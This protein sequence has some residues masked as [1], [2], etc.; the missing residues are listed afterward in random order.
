MDNPC[1][2]INPESGEGCEADA[3]LLI[4]SGY[5]PDDYTYACPYHAE[6]LFIDGPFNHVFP[7]EEE[8]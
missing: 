8:K 4:V 1:C 3:E 7:L 2:Y 6:N 5:S